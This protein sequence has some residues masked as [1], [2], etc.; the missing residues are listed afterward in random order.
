VDL[1]DGQDY[2]VAVTIA[3][4]VPPEPTG[5]FRASMVPI[6]IQ[7]VA[8]VIRARVRDP[9]FPNTPV[10]VVLQPKQFSAVCRQVYWRRAMAGE[11]FPGH[12]ATCLAIWKADR[13]PV[14][15]GALWYYSPVSM[16]PPGR[17]P[18]WA[19]EKTAVYVE[20]LD[21]YYFR[22]FR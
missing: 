5:T 2:V 8:D 4:E 7:A 11:W 1:R 17:E 18:S 13:P 20:H 19:A 12:V 10:E 22:F 9:R 16:V 14:A 21:P 15:P 3:T 6:A